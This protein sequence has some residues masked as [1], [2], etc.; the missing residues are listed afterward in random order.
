MDMSDAERALMMEHVKYTHG[1]FAAGKVLIFGPVMDPK[2]AFGMAVFEAGD[3]AEVR[4]IMEND[5]TVKA[6][7]N[8][9]EIHAMRVGAAQ[10][11]R[12]ESREASN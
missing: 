11:S 3:E 7:L 10:G 8:T 1:Q 4:A 6:G 5:P 9:F 12:G 2:G